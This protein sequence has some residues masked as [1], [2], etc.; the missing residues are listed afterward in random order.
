MRRNST[1]PNYIKISFFALLLVL[2]QVLSNT[3]LFMPT[4]VGVFFTYIIINIS[5][6]EDFFYIILS[7]LYLSFYELNKGFYL[8]T[9]VVLFIFYYY[10]FDE[11]IRNY[12]KCKNC[13]LFVYVL[14]AYVGHYFMN[15]L[16]AY[17]LN[18]HFPSF[19][20]EYLY[21][22]AFDFVISVFIFRRRIEN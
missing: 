6:E 3:F 1:N 22:I 12:F 14:I 17:L 9:Y 10:L 7:F 5:H 2:L 15:A 11:K 16:F 18:E 13:I 19:T 8:F 21:Y 4:F 20:L